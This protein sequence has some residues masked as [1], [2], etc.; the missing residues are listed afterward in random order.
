MLTSLCLRK[1]K[2]LQILRAAQFLDGSFYVHITPFTFWQPWLLR[3]SQQQ[4]PYCNFL[5][6]C[7][8]IDHESLLHKADIPSHLPFHEMQ[9]YWKLQYAFLPTWAIL[10]SYNNLFTPYFSP[11]YRSVSAIIAIYCRNATFIYHLHNQLQ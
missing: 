8:P 11:P 7:A 6:K 3:L 1:H 4:L 9:Y 2:Q 10:P 5:H